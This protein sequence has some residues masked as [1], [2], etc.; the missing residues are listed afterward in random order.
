MGSAWN[1]SGMK[2]MI[3][4]F[5]DS[6]FLRVSYLDD[7]IEVLESFSD[8][9]TMIMIMGIVAIIHALITVGALVHQ[10]IRPKAK[11]IFFI[12]SGIAITVWNL[13]TV[14]VINDSFKIF[15]EDVLE[16]D[17]LVTGTFPSF[18]PAIISILVLVNQF[19]IKPMELGAGM[20]M[21]G[22][23]GMQ[24][25]AKPSYSP[26]V[27]PQMQAAPM[28]KAPAA[29]QSFCPS[30]GGA[31]SSEAVFCPNCGT[32]VAKP[33]PAEKRCIGCQ[34]VLDADAVFCPNCGAKNE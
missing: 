18:V 9:A 7:I 34:T 22:G 5:E 24:Y 11:S 13:I 20:K 8:A 1:A 29:G 15:A 33:Q 30:C 17:K 31:M 14:S 4:D 10:L 6:D 26:Y 12:A 28:A 3:D 21:A 16:V 2:D 23:V 27:Q 19:V 32:S 25:G